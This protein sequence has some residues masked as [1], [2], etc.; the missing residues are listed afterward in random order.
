MNTTVEK[1]VENQEI[2]NYYICANKDVRVDKNGNKFM[3]L[4]LMN[5]SGIIK[6][7]KW[8]VDDNLA[9]SFDQGQV[10]KIA[11]RVK[12]SNYSGELE[13]E[14]DI[15]MPVTD[16]DEVDPGLLQPASPRDLAG[17]EAELEAIRDSITNPDLTMLLNGI[18][19]DEKLYRQF[20]QAPAAKG[21]HHNYIHGL[22]EH[23]VAVCRVASAVADQYADAVNRDLLVTGALLHDIGKMAEFKYATNID[24]SDQ[25][26][27]L[28]HIVMGEK[29]VSDAIASLDD[30]PDELRLQLLHLIL[31]HHGEKEYGSPVRPKTLEG[32]ILNHADNIDAKANMFMKLHMAADETGE[33]WSPFNRIL[34]RFLYMRKA[35]D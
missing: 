8:R 11:G 31:S 23:T 27:L 32:F 18:F 10:V 12:K 28:G 25:G 4:R 16:T 13:I 1:P 5:T 7:V 21:V 15:I 17:M 2:E 30:F 9:E 26:R 6:A 29:L 22:L 19:S 20:C 14:L 33:S 35:E 24:Y 3:L 34:D